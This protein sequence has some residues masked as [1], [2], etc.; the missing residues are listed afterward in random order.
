MSRAIGERDLRPAVA[1]SWRPQRCRRGRARSRRRSQSPSPAPPPASRD[2]DPA[3]A[4]EARAGRKSAGN[5]SP[6]SRHAQRRPSRSRP[7]PPSRTVPA[8]C[9]SALSTRLPSACSRRTRSPV[10]TSSSRRGHLELAPRRSRTRV[11]ATRDRVEDLAHGVPVEAQRKP[12]LVGPREHE[13][14]LGEPHEPLDLLRRRAKRASSSSCERGR[15]QRELELGAERRERRPQLVAR[16]GDEAALARESLLEAAEHLVQRLAEAADL[17]ARRRQRE[18]PV[19]ALARDLGRA[20]P[21]RLDRPKRR[22]GEEVPADEV[23]SSASGPTTSE[24]RE[25]A[26]ERLVA[27]LERLAGNDEVVARPPSTDLTRIEPRRPRRPNA[28]SSRSTKHRP[29]S[30]PRALRRSSREPRDSGSHD[31]P[32]PG[33]EHEREAVLLVGNAD[34][35]ERLLPTSAAE[36]TSRRLEAVVD[37]LVQRAPEPDVEQR[38]DDDEHER[39]RRRERERQPQ[40]QRDAA[41]APACRSRYPT[42]RTVSSECRPNGRSI[43]PRR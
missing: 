33:P 43:F 14:I 6:S 36:R 1:A 22:A 3:E 5:P 11:E 41:H 42:P 40:P 20:A 21:H 28:V 4:L 39:H 26:V 10:K 30:R 35:A 27:I 13:Q 8:P 18:P 7:R 29:R 17:V 38:A 37:L 9:R 34:L 25:E 19:G 32:V 31:A 15:A 24:L 16:V 23:R 12:A 2:V